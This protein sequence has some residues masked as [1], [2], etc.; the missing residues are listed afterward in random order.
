MGWLSVR[1]LRRD[2]NRRATHVEAAELS[3]SDVGSIP[4]ASTK[5]AGLLAGASKPAF[6]G[7]CGLYSWART[8][9]GLGYHGA[10]DRLPLRFLALG[11]AAC[12][13]TPLVGCGDS[14]RI[15]DLEAE[16]ARLAGEL[17]DAREE[18]Q[19]LRFQ[20]RDRISPPREAPPSRVPPPETTSTPPPELSP[21]LQ[22]AFEACEIELQQVQ[23]ELRAAQETAQRYRE[24]GERAVD[25]LNRRAGTSPRS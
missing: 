4:T 16:N 21:R 18:M 7:E 20:T 2:F 22:Q 24:A 23:G 10:M 13:L 12:L 5:F 15:Q 3:C 14:Q 17:A 8:S 1:P 25:E 9:P 11:V 6:S 19:T